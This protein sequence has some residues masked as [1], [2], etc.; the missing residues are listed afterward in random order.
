MNLDE[1]RQVI[2][3][4]DAQMVALFEKRMGAVREVALYKMEQGLPVFDSAREQEVIARNVALL[5]DGSLAKYFATFQNAAM[6]VSRAYQHQVM[7]D[8]FF[9]I[10]SLH[11]EI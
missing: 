9:L 3:E 4:C 1:A 11:S 6:G 8:F 5:S 7:G 10:L 2:N